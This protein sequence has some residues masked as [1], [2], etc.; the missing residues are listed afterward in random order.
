MRSDE[1]RRRIDGPIPRV[2]FL[3][4][5]RG[6]AALYVV[7]HH[8]A[9]LVPPIGLGWPASVVRFLLRHG[10]YAVT[11]FLVLSGYG[12]MHR[13]LAEPGG[14]L[15][16]GVSA[17][18]A[19]RARRILP[20]VLC[21]ARPLLAPDRDSPRARASLRHALGPRLAGLGDGC[22]PIPPPPDPQPRRPLDLSRRAAVLEPGDGLAD[23]SP[24]PSL[25][26]LHRCRG[27]SAVVAAGFG[28]GAAVELLAIPLGNP[29][30]R[31]LCP[32]YFGLFALGMAGAATR[33][34][35]RARTDGRPGPPSSRRSPC[36][37]RLGRRRLSRGHRSPGG[38]AVVGL[39]V[40]LA[41]RARPARSRTPP[42]ACSARGRPVGSATTR[43]AFT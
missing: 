7:L 41:R 35:V 6:L 1:P 31:A 14:R 18:L 33:S 36:S 16:G 20:P 38:P 15:P 24:L 11:A 19:R 5:L 17:Y 9:L 23:L 10:H 12:L 4:G 3:D 37:R 39:V 28:L 29:A 42:S 27:P 43:I 22:R 13:A 8:A 40:W 34:R 26:V 2:G 32:W 30:L 21:G 25:P